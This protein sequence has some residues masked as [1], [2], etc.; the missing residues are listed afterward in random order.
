MK[1]EL[2]RAAFITQAPVLPS[3]PKTACRMLVPPDL[4]A[5]VARPPQ[6]ESVTQD[7]AMFAYKCLTLPSRTF[8]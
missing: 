3:D 4:S 5:A 7:A 6:S 8:A 2:S 1:E